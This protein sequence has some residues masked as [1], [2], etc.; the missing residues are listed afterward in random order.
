MKKFLRRAALLCAFALPLVSCAQLNSAFGD[1]LAKADKPSL[2]LTGARISDLRADGVTLEFDVDVLN[3]YKL[4]MPLTNIKYG[5]NVGD[6]V[7]DATASPLFAG[8]IESQGS[9]PAGGKKSFTVPVEVGFT[10][11]LAAVSAIKPGQ[12]VPY[13]TNLGFAVKVPGT[14]ESLELPV[15]HK[16]LFPVPAPPDISVGDIAWKELSLSKASGELRLNVKNLNQFTASLSDL[17]YGLKLNGTKIVN[18][19]IPKKMDF[20]ANGAQELVIPLE[21]K[22]LDFGFAAFNMLKGGEA[23]YSLDGN[24]KVDTPYG[25]LKQGFARTGSTAMGGK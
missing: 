23:N 9:I 2:D 20:E 17:N 10:Q 15:E 8:A 24:V 22:P 18:G 5:L 4:A 3:P 11:L 14:Q 16:G 21:I 13:R 6:G 25:A 1:M 12:V 19:A 7:A